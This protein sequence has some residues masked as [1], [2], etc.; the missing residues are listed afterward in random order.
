VTGRTVALVIEGK[1][2]T[3]KTSQVI[4]RS[5]RSGRPFILPSARTRGWARD[6]RIQM[7]MQYRGAPLTGPV[8]VNYQVYRAHDR[9][10]LGG[11]E[12]AIDDA[13]EGVVI[14]NDRQII[15]RT[16]AKHIFRA[17]PRVHVIVYTVGEAVEP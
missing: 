7:R 8:I 12:A 16:S 11:F 15:A 9:G 10:D 17:R 1:P 5:P 3:A 2:A 6:A 4:A 13:L 14:V